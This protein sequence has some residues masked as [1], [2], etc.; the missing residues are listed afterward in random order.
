MKLLNNNNRI[1]YVNKYSTVNI[2]FNTSFFYSDQYNSNF[3]LHLIRFVNRY[4]DTN[5]TYRV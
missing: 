4:K 5:R 1:I 3:Q 2:L